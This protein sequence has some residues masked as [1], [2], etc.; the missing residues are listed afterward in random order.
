MQAA[1]VLEDGFAQTG[2]SI[3]AP[4]ERIGE[5]VFNTS[6][7]GYQEILTDPSYTGQIVLMTYPL[8]G[9]YGVN[10]EDVES[11][12]LY[13]EGL[14]IRQLSG[15]RSNFRSSLDLDAYLK[16]N[17]VVAIEGV[18]TRMLA[19]RIRSQGAMRAMISTG[20]KPIAA[21]VEQIRS[22]PRMEG[23]DLVP[24]VTGDGCGVFP[25]PPDSPRKEGAGLK[26]VAMDFGIKK[27]I[28]RMLNHFGVDVEVVHARTKP[29]EI[30]QRKP[31]GL[32]LSNGPGDPAAVTYAV[33][34]VRELLGAIPIFGI[35]LGHQ[36]MGIVFGG[37]TLKLKFGHHGANHPVKDIETGKIE[38]TTQNHGF[39]VDP[40][41]LKGTGAAVTHVNLN[42]GTVEGIRH[43]KLRA[44]SVQHH[45]EASPGPHDSHHMFER[46]VKSMHS[47]RS[48]GLRASCGINALKNPA[49]PQPCTQ[50][51]QGQPHPSPPNP[52]GEGE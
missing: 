4:G 37:R 36:I 51:K 12:K 10:E 9:N 17:G 52:R 42:D 11:L 15:I 6:M 24:R 43:E 50:A 7:T 14:V 41:S 39:A 33:S 3:G 30:M 29:A 5:I 38:I 1:I 45:P 8:I 26:V 49:K 16:A 18:D 32:F 25:A 22:A 44:F 35:C 21:L 19:K 20:K 40:D 34:T 47:T 23:L 31:D 48:V 27:N 28:I 2:R 46:F 13:L